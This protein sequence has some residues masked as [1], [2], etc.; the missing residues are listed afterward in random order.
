MM[1]ILN[2][3]ITCAFQKVPEAKAETIAEL[4]MWKTTSWPFHKCPHLKTACKTA[5]ISLNWMSLEW[6]WQGHLAENQESPNM[7]PRPFEPLALVYTCSM[8]PARSSIWMPFQ[9]IVCANHQKISVCTYPGTS[10]GE[11]RLESH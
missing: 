5:Y 10:Q 3:F 6:N 1:I 11:I 7:P 2:M 4:L 9:A 8:W